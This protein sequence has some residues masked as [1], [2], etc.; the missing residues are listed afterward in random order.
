MNEPNLVSI[1][2]IA[3]IAV[4]ILLSLE[5][6]VISLISRL[7]PSL[8]SDTELVA[9]VIEQAVAKQFPGAKVVAIDEVDSKES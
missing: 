2:V 7:F 4:M 3:F 8:K 5:A 9:E 1:C 6:L